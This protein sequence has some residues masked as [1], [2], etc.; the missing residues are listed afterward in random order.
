MDMLGS[1]ES[2]LAILEYYNNTNENAMLTE[3]IEGATNL[4]QS[5]QSSET[6]SVNPNYAVDV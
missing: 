2:R 6:R 4:S 3:A 5:E 1:D